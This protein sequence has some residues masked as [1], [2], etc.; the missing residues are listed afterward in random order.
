MATATM[1][2]IPISVTKIAPVANLIRGKNV[3]YALN[4][5]NSLNKKGA[6]Y[7][8]KLLLSATSNSSKE[9]TKETLIVDTIYA[10][11]GPTKMYKRM[12]FAGRGRI[13]PYRKYHSNLF[14]SLS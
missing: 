9:G 11:T 6:K 12:R 10:S 5:M 14:V 4:V 13:K 1:K 3:D 8:Y 2:N 7:I